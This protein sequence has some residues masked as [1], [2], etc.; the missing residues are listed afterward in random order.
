MTK[1]DAQTDQKAFV[2]LR[3][4]GDD[5]DPGDI[6]AILTVEPTRAH[7]KGE[8]FFTGPHSGNLRGRTG[9]WFLATDTLVASDDLADHL[10]FVQDLLYPAP[11]NNG[12]ITRTRNLLERRHAARPRYLLLARRSRRNRPANPGSVQGSSRVRTQLVQ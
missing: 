1:T 9:M 6:S 12:R 4:A 7:R 2:T 3:F 5:L 11:S 8:E 10:R